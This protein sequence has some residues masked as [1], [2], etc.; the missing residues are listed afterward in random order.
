MYLEHH[1]SCSLLPNDTRKIYK[2][3]YSNQTIHLRHFRIYDRIPFYQQRIYRVATFLG[4]AKV[5]TRRRVIY[6]NHFLPGFSQCFCNTKRDKISIL[7]LL[8]ESA[9]RK[10]SV[11]EK[12][13]LNAQLFV[14][15]TPKMTDKISHFRVQ[16]LCEARRIYVYTRRAT[17]ANRRDIVWKCSRS[18]WVEGSGGNEG[19]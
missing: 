11:A 3:V 14:H 12:Y 4:C 9:H 17:Y 5:E 10:R 8:K 7:H 16:S 18:D 2:I 1:L 19:V 15:R 6:P 13:I